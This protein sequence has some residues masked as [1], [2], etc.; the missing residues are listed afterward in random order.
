MIRLSVLQ[1]TDRL[2]AHGFAQ[3]TIMW[4]LSNLTP[5]RA[6]ATSEG[7]GAAEWCKFDAG[8][9]GG[10]TRR[11]GPRMLEWRFDIETS[12]A[13]ILDASRVDSLP[14][15]TTG[16]RPDRQVHDV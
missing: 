2:R 13:L 8:V 1:V 11:K 7:A 3:T 12:R 14:L 6:P 5:L 4:L 15:L 10:V 16:F 9:V